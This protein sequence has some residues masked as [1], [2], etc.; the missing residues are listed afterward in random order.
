L[1]DTGKQAASAA[2]AM[3]HPSCQALFKHWDERRGLSAIPER[4]EIDPGS[5]RQALGDTFILAFNTLNGHIFRLAGTRICA[6]VGRELKGEGF[7]ALWDERDRRRLAELI[8]AAIDDSVGLLAAVQGTNAD[9]QTLDLE[10]ILL[11]LTHC[12]QTHLRLIGT[13]APITVPYWLGSNPV[14]ALTL[15]D[16]RFVGHERLLR[17]L[18]PAITVTPSPAR[19]R[20]KFTVYDGGRV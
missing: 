1:R 4:S 11:P 6:L 13:L 17:P 3:K 12:G 8:R 20:P 2:T 15:G 7:I 10:L 18:K 9:C 16:Y 19:V 14:R 5:L